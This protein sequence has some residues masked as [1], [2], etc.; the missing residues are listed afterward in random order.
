VGDWLDTLLFAGIALLAAMVLVLS[1]AEAALLSVN[2]QLLHR[3][4]QKGDQ[5]AAAVEAL[6]V[7]GDYLSALIVGINT[8]I[9]LISTLATVVVYRALKQG[10]AWRE[11]VVHLATLGVLLVFA[12]LTP[13]TYGTLYADSLARWVG[14]AVAGLTRALAGPVRVLTGLANALLTLLRVPPLHHRRL[15]TPGD[16]QAAA[17]LGEEAGVVEPDQGEMLDAI[18]ELGETTARDVMVPR[19]NIVGVPRTATLEQALDKAATSGFSRL[20]VYEDSLDSIVGI[21]HVNDLLRCL[22]TGSDWHAYI[23][24]PLLVAEATPLREVFRQMRQARTHMAIVA[25]EFGGTAG[26][27]TVEDILEELVGEIR[28][29]HDRGEAEILSLRPGELLVAGH[30]RVEEVYEQLDLP[31]PALEAETIAGM[32]AQLTGHIPLTGEQIEHEGVIFRVEESDGQHVAR[33][34]VAVKTSK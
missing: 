17:D 21:V 15:V 8:A 23:R 32:L 2:R 3:E 22:V 29:E 30:A 10:P 12:E 5:R 18:I 34:R 11:E 28:D 9:V 14:P 7:S 33:V 6:L 25:D 19:I 1:L 4:A 16:I 31:P 24:A 13:K 27:V 20:P 26:L